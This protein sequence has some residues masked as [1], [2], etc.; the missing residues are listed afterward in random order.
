MSLAEFKRVKTPIPGEVQF[1]IME[2]QKDIESNH[3]MQ[4][5]PN[6]APD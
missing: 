6:G 2:L 5:T 3:A 4:A 1:L